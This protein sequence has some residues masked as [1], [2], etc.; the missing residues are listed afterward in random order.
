MQFKVRGRFIV[1]EVLTIFFPRAYLLSVDFEARVESDTD[2]LAQGRN[3]FL[4]A[5]N[6][7]T[8]MYLTSPITAQR[9]IAQQTIANGNT[10]YRNKGRPPLELEDQVIF[11][12]M[13]LGDH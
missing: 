2:M 7:L 1:S 5:G 4:P 12:R 13:I 10:Y 9:A 11:Q 8:D 3:L 6:D